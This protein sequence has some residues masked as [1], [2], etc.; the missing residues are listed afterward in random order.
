MRI[1]VVFC[2]LLMTFMPGYGQDLKK[3]HQAMNQ[4]DPQG[5]KQ[6]PWKKLYSNGSPQYEGVFVNDRP[7]GLFRRYYEDGKVSALLEYRANSNR[8]YARIYYENETLAG[9]GVY[10]GEKKDSLWKYYSFYGGNLTQEESYM[11][12]LKQGVSRKYY[13]SGTVSEITTWKDGRKDGTW[14]RYYENG[15]PMLVS[16]YQYDRIDGPYVMYYPDGTMQL[17]GSFIK[18]LREGRWEYF[19]EQGKSQAVIQFENGNPLN[20]AELNQKEREFLDSLENNKGKIAEPVMED[21]IKPNQ[22]PP[23][24]G[25]K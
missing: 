24:K 1:T 3:Y 25:K 4:T 9:E 21:L 10:V 12:G 23:K 15:T 18:N 5:R 11:N 17:K 8:V 20:A 6:G 14:E 19:D 2:L 22:P 7:V 16:S 13:P